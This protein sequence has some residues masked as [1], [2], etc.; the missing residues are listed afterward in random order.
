MQSISLLGRSLATAAL[1]AATAIACASSN[2]VVDDSAASGGDSSNG[3]A[4]GGTASVGGKAGKGGTTSGGGTSTGGNAG[5]SAVNGGSG[6][7]STGSGAGGRLGGAGQPAQAGGGGASAAACGNGKLEAGEECDDG[8]TKDGDGCSSICTNKCEQCEAA[9]CSS[10]ADLKP[11]FEQ[12]YGDD[13]L[14][15]MPAQGGPAAGTPRNK[16]CQALIACVRRTN[17]QAGSPGDPIT[18]CLCGTANAT[19]CTANATGPCADEVAAAAESRT[20]NDI[21]Q[22]S[23]GGNTVYAVGLAFNL[24]SNCD[25]SACGHECLQDKAASACDQCALGSD[26]TFFSFVCDSYYSCY[27]DNSQSPELCTPAADCALR[28]GCAAGGVASCYGAGSGPCAQEF[29]AAAKSTD[30]ATVAQRLSDMTYP[31]GVADDLLSCDLQQCKSTCF[32]NASSGTG[33]SGGAGGHSAGGTGGTSAAGSG[34][35]STGGAS[36]GGGGAGG[37]S[38]SSAAVCGNDILEAGEVCDPKYSADNCGSDCKAITD[39]TCSACEQQADAVSDCGDV[40]SCETVAGNAMNGPAAGTPRSNLC[41]EV[42]DCVRD[43]SCATNNS[44]LTCYCGLGTSS[45]DCQA[46]LG[47]GLCRAQIEAGL[48]AT[49]YATIIKRLKDVTFGGGLALKRIADCDQSWCNVECNE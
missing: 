43:T 7:T 8:N 1:L 4:G 42:L 30:P 2:D 9:D 5:T 35:H 32:P 16:L 45:T 11:V 46:G 36:A 15:T 38:G 13:A 25:A 20:F 3:G 26:P 41:N 21:Q 33:G 23:A 37:S 47:N 19:A 40:V 48:E 14:A 10:S 6:G 31:L 17:C 39:V 27:F 34:G 22:R 18:P 44:I 29:A 12:C 28:T 49:D 24:L